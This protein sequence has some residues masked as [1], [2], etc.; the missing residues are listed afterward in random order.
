MT[1]TLEQIEQDLNSKIPASAVS[2][3][4]GGGGKQLSYLAG[5][6]VIDRLN[7]VFGPFGWASQTTSIDKLFEGEVT[8]RYGK[9]TNYV[10]YR[11]TVRLVVTGPDNKATEHTLN[12]FGDGQD[13]DNAGKAHELAI[14]EAETDALKRCA[15]NLGMSMGLALYD[16]TQENV[17]Q[18]ET[19]EPKVEEKSAPK[20]AATNNNSASKQTRDAPKPAQAEENDHVKVLNLIKEVSGALISTGK[21]SVTELKEELKS[22]YGVDR[23]EGLTSKQAK[24]FLANLE[25]KVTKAPATASA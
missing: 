14:K 22:K 23:K 5:H 10:S 24:E 8:N 6:Y 9:K 20:S 19:V 21:T 15:K 2:S 4:E 11:A 13:Q 18:D 1:R 17:E 16:K 3:R 7:K 25:S 12:G